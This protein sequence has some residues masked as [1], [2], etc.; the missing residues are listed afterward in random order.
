MASYKNLMR[1]RLAIKNGSITLVCQLI[2]VILGFV[3]RKMFIQYIGIEMLAINSTFASLLNTFSLAELGFESAIIYSLYKPL[4]DSNRNEIEDIV[5]LL[6]HFYKVIGMFIFIVGIIISF[7]LPHII[8]GIEVDFEIYS[9]YYLQLVGTVVTYFLAYK[10]TFLLAE[11]KD[12]IRNIFT[13]IYKIFATLIQIVLIMV[14]QSFLLYVLIS[15]IQNFI[16]N[17]SIALY[18]DKNYEYRFKRKFNVKLF[19]KIWED[20]KD[21]FFSKIA[22]YIYSSTD[23]LIISVML[24]TVYVGFLG[25]YTQII[26]QLKAVVSNVFTS[27]RPIIGRFLT[28]EQDRTHIFQVLKNYTFVRYV[29]SVAI[30]VPCFVLCDCFI[31]SWL[32][33]DYV[34]SWWIS[35]FLVTDIYIHFVH[36]ALVDYIAG[37]GYF[38]Y[39]KVIS[40]IGA[41]INLITSIVLT[42]FIGIWGVLLG[43]IISQVFFWISRS[44]IVFKNY[45]VDRIKFTNYWT[46]N[47][48]YI[49]VFYLLCI[50]CRVLFEII[51]VATSYIKFIIGGIGCYI[52]I[53]LIIY[54][55]FSRTKEFDY[56]INIIKKVIV[57]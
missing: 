41:T 44:I 15:I 31:Y 57:R 43:T 10:K 56:L 33:V 54:G 37:L 46:I 40:I 11:Q 47:I 38:R 16:T 5:S 28:D 22:G 8:T 25:N 21:I 14:Y 55:I 49:S 2:E 13:M 27:T 6:K 39:D 36:G 53:L 42:R 9:V 45:F 51:P 7:F 24:G 32:G 20:V 12:Y 17:L 35:L 4:R 1:N 34:M 52:V 19:K 50:G 30:L 48:G 29:A 18:V 3:V 26:Y 23:N